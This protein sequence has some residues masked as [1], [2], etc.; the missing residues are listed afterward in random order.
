MTRRITLFRRRSEI[1]TF[2]IIPNLYYLK[3]LIFLF[4]RLIGGCYASMI[5]FFI[6]IIR[7]LL[8]IAKILLE[9]LNCSGEEVKN[10]A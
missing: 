5:E 6:I 9:E 8:S 1:F 7:N 2:S 3:F 10:L 4:N